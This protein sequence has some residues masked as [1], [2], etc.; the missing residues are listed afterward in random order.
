MRIFGLIGKTLTHSF[1]PNYFN[2]KF[3]V[4]NILDTCY[5][6]FPLENIEGILAL[7]NPKHKVAGLNVTFPYKETVIPYLDGLSE[8]AQAIGA[9]NT[10]ECKADGKWIGHN[11]DAQGFEQCILGTLAKQG[12]RALV[13]GTGGA[14]KAVQYV[15]SKHQVPFQLVSRNTNES[16]HHIAYDEINEN[17]IEHHLLIINCTPLGTFPN[18]NECPNIP[19]EF[20]GD[21]H[22]VFD[23]VY[24]P[25]ETLLMKKAKAAGAAVANGSSMLE[26][27]AEASWEIWNK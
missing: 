9:V 2:E 25:A 3:K 8:T 10:I 22:F 13:L 5:E 18:I 17:I 27:Q 19:F 1:S 24:N 14:A 23:L 20:I 11:T 16:L 15:L 7:K 6:L 12:I 4:E 26:N 21:K